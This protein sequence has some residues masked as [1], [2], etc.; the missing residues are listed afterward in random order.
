MKNFFD[1]TVV[2]Y[3]NEKTAIDRLIA[4]GFSRDEILKRMAR[5][6]ADNEEEKLADFVITITGDISNTERQ[7]RRILH[8]QKHD[9]TLKEIPRY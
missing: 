7:I 9:F 2:A 6:N 3:C 8:K 4:K 1:K 5:S